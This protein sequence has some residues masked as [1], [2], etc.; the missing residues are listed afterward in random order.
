MQSEQLAE[1]TAQLRR[2]HEA[3]RPPKN[4]SFAFTRPCMF[5]GTPEG[6]RCGGGRHY[7]TEHGHV[8]CDVHLDELEAGIT[9]SLATGF[10]IRRVS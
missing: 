2:E 9:L 6:S 8:L 1:I 4:R 7:I 5:E 10:E 3:T